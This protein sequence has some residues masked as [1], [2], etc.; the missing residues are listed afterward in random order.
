MQLESEEIT[1]R[2]FASYCKSYGYGFSGSFIHVR[3]CCQQSW[4]PY[5]CAQKHLFDEQGQWYGNLFFQFNKTIIG[6]NFGE[7]MAHVLEDSFL[8]RNASDNGILSQGKVS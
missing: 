8:I 3:E 5:I 4:Y 7:E 1:H 6:D 2:T